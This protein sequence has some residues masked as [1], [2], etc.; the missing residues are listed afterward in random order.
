MQCPCLYYVR[1]TGTRVSA[2]ALLQDGG[3][4]MDRNIVLLQWVHICGVMA[5][6]LTALLLGPIKRQTPLTQDG[7]PIVQNYLTKSSQR[8]PLYY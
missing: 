1:L 3:A 8:K 2:E 4:G 5:A 6:D 7:F